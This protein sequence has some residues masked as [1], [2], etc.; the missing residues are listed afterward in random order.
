MIFYVPLSSWRDG[1]LVLGFYP[2]LTAFWEDFRSSMEQGATLRFNPFSYASSAQLLLEKS[3]VAWSRKSSSYSKLQDIALGTAGDHIRLPA[4]SHRGV[5]RRMAGQLP[6][7]QVPN[8]YHSVQFKWFT[9]KVYCWIWN[10]ALI[11]QIPNVEKP[12]KSHYQLLFS[13]LLGHA[14][15]VWVEAGGTSMN[16][17]DSSEQYRGTSKI[18]R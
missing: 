7:E 11:C 2:H 15:C 14:V 3:E 12:L 4:I 13:Y 17:L 1:D 6:E 10:Y 5:K 8:S 16:H 18:G 9:A